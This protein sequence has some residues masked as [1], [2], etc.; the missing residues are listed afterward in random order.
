MTKRK[1]LIRC[2]PFAI[3]ASAALPHT[4]A[5]AQDAATTASPVVVLPPEQ[6]AAPAP[7]TA[8][9]AAP[10][11]A[12]RIVL[13]EVTPAPAPAAALRAAPSVEAAPVAEAAPAAPVVRTAPRAETRASVP[14]QPRPER[15]SAAAPAQSVVA[16]RPAAPVP[17]APPTAPV[18]APIAEPVAAPTAQAEAA[19]VAPLRADRA[20]EG[21]IAGLLAALGLAAVGGVAFAA[22]RRRRARGEAA[23]HGTAIAPS[24]VAAVMAEP[25]HAAPA[26][27]QPQPQPLAATPAAATRGGDP[28]TLPPAIPADFRER[29]ALLKQLVEAKPDRANPFRSTGARTRRARLIIQSLGATFE[30]RKPRFDL[31]QY[32]QRWPALRGWQPAT[33]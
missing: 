6:P 1:L 23:V 20:N 9:T 18:A 31:S 3:A 32:A 28:V 11:P 21:M 22:S 14:A 19:P 29:D 33:A 5:L 15:A 26:A 10:A 12:P 30:D 27:V 16:E 24:P 4:A 2:A 25:V 17:T 13:P 7:V 8:A